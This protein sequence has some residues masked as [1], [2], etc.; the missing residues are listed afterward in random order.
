[1]EYGKGQ[2]CL[3]VSKKI[4]WIV[5]MA[6]RYF[7]CLGHERNQYGELKNVKTKVYDPA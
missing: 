6:E 1:M 7:I 5:N 3:L 2:T 4:L